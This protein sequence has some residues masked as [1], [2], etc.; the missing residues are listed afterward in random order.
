MMKIKIR[1]IDKALALPEYKTA[2]AAGFDIAA[3]E[4]VTIAPHVVGYVPLNIA[5]ET[6]VGYFLLLAAR[7][8]THKKGLLLA[9]GVGIGDSDFAGDSDEYKAAY[10]NF[11]D[12]PVVI[13][14]GERIAQGIFIKYET[15]Q[16]QEVEH[17]ENPTRGGFGSTGFA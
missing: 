8:S 2:G 16:W 15:A 13:Q 9:N 4:D 3:K 1:R 14:K 12:A 6:P 17:L 11:T 5:V 10:L 7:S